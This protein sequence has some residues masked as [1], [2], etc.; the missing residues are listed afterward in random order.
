MPILNYTTQI[1]AEKTIAEIQEKLAKFG[2]QS[3][4]TEYNDGIVSALFFRITSSQGFLSY[5]IPTKYEQIFYL[6]KGDKKVPTKLKTKE[7]AAKVA[8]RI[9]KDWIE[10]QLA[11]IEADQVELKEVFLPFMQIEVGKTLYDKIKEN[12]FKLLTD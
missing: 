11:F 8:W 6:L 10:A 9:V 4:L 12:D 1:K 5:R 3:V 7:Q 2:V